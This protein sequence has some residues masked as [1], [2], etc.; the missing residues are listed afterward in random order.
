MDLTAMVEGKLNQ[1]AERIAEGG[2]RVD[3]HAL[4]ELVFYMALRRAL[5]GSATPQDLGMLDAVNDT[6]QEL[7]L[8]DSGTTFYRD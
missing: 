3:E 1:Y 2:S 8:I 5:S 6:L 4:G 7:G